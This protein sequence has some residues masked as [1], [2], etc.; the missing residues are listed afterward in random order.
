MFS[1]KNFCRTY[2]FVMKSDPGISQI[3]MSIFNRKKELYKR[4]ALDNL[5]RQTNNNSYF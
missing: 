4:K 5:A 2:F 3:M 1:K